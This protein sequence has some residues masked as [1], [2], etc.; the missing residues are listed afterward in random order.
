MRPVALRFAACSI[1]LLFLPLRLAA[2][3]ATATLV[4][5]V[6]ASEESALPGV[7]VRLT[8]TT[9][10]VEQVLTTNSDGSAAASL[11]PAGEYNVLAALSGYAP[12]ASTIRLEPG[13]KRVLD[14]H[15]RPA[16]FRETVTVQGTS[17]A[18][19][20]S[21]TVGDIFDGRVLIMTPV[22][23]RDFLQFAQQAPGAVPPAPGS[24]LSTQANAG[25]NVSGAR[26]AANNFLLDGIDNNDQ[27]LNRLVVTPSLEAVQEFTLLQN[28]YDAEYGRSAGAQ[29]N[30]VLKSGGAAVHGSLFEYFR[31]ETLDA[32]GALDPV[33]EPKPPFS[34]HQV[35]GT[36]GGPVARSRMFYFASVEAVRTRSAETRLAHVPTQAARA[37]DFSQSD[38]TVRD[39]FTGEPFLGNRIPH[40]RLDQAGVRVATLYPDPNRPGELNL[41]SSPPASRDGVQLTVKLDRAGW[42]HAPLALRYSLT[43][44][45]RTEPFPARGRNIPGFGTTVVDV[46]QHAAASL[47]QTSGTRWFNELRTG[48]NRLRR[49]NVAMSRGRDLFGELGIV[50]PDLA[51]VDRGYPTFT[52]AGYETLGDDPNL[53]VVRRAQTIHVSD[54]LTIHRGRHQVKIGGELRHYRS[55][56]FNHL[57]GRGQVVFT[58]AFTGDALADLLLG[59]PSF[60]LIAA[61]D[62][63]QALRTA[64]WNVFVQH[65]WHLR[66]DLTLNTGIR[67]E[68]NRAPVDAT[69]RMRIFDLAGRRLRNVGE[70]GV[71][72]SGVRSDWNNL[73]PRLGVAWKLPGAA[74][75][76]LRGGVGVY[77]DAG[78]LIENSALYF[79]PPFF[80]LQTYFPADELLQL[81]DPFPAGRGFRPLP[82]VNTLDP[83]FR[84][85]RTTQGSLAVEDRWGDVN[86]VARYVSSRGSHLPRRRNVNQPV[87]GPGPLDDR[88]DIPGFA[89]ILVVEPA[90]SSSYDALQLKV[91]RPRTE[92]LSVR[93]SYSLGRSSDDASAFL[94]SEGNDNTPQD[95]RRPEAEWGPSDFDVRQRLSL[96]A[97]YA[98]PSAIDRGWL[99]DWQVSALLTVQSGY[100]FTPRV[101]FD[102]SNTGNVGGAFGFDR[103]DEIDPSAAPPGAVFY[104]GRA[105]VVAPTFTFGNAGRNILRGP[106]LATVDLAVMRGFRLGN[107]RLETRLEVYNALN[108]T[109]L[110]LPDSFVDRPTFGRS[111]SARPP[112]EVQLAVRFEF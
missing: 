112:R 105:F 65:D 82:S 57:F 33:D 3:T 88:R 95:A 89:D 53:P 24:R 108:H 7:E 42:E 79:N 26:E 76:T 27:F 100:P 90:A 40:D 110:G 68:F 23:D 31:D 37:G 54:A 60:S 9:T 109:N 20:H 49:E 85:A 12:Q 11:L 46:G 10:R 81:G 4:V 74:E 52:L 62:N 64:A 21:G 56:G 50:G 5:Q 39:P 59:L 71:P 99:R 101:G 96:A 86:V 107:R 87:P 111:L 51:A 47:T 70:D 106:G 14:L 103:P 63:R 58:G 32:R 34:R 38:V 28:T 93:A 16:G 78:T 19:P 48:W 41:V 29:V 72:R 98:T 6:R 30:V 55:D 102:N 91:E 18:R 17:T 13:G 44:D 92:G 8:N 43:A 25:V 61:N 15:L 22:Q 69:D 84:T 66:S 97:I 1:V 35:G 77:Y 94:Q 104:D 2:Q 36:I 73:A 83:D 67:Y 75:L 80:D 45:D